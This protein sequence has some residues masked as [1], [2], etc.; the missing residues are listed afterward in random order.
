[1]KIILASGSPRRRE[2]LDSLGLSYEVMVRKEKEIIKQGLTI[3]EQVQDLAYQKAKWAFDQTKGDRI[4]IGADTIVYKGKKIY[5]KPKD[6]KQAIEFMQEMQGNSQNVITGLA[7]LIE[8]EKKKEEYLT[9]DETEVFFKSMDLGEILL[10]I[11]RGH[12]YDKAGG[13]AI[14]CFA[15]VFITK[16]IGNVDTVIGLPTAKLYDILKKQGIFVQGGI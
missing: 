1:M 7:V 6:K 16:I 8:K 9:F 14:Q 5:G 13:W 2:M 10:N 4:V 15:R 3:Q 11:E 12:P